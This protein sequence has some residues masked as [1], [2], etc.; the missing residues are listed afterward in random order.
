MTWTIIGL[1]ERV[2]QEMSS[3]AKV[4]P[5]DEDVIAAVSYCMQ[6]V[7]RGTDSAANA[8]FMDVLHAPHAEW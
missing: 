6:I 2:P 1:G 7:E 3:A 4:L 8:K 5:L